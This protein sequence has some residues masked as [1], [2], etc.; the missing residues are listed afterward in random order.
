MKALLFL[1]V[2]G[3]Y[4][5]QAHRFIYELKF[6]SDSLQTNLKYTHMVLDI[7]K[8]IKFYDLEFLKIDSTG[9]IGINSPKQPQLPEF[10]LTNVVYVK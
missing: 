1:L 10:P 2:F 9:V 7:E 5:S 4:N 3:L 8:E 6:K